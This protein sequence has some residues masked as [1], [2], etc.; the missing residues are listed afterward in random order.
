MT[1]VKL[2]YDDWLTCTVYAYK[3]QALHSAAILNTLKH[4]KADVF[5]LY[6]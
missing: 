2:A 6:F 3:L 1:I 4:V 5:C